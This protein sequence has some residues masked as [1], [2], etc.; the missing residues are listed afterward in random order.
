MV[1]QRPETTGPRRTRLTVRR[2]D[3][4]SVL[5]FS[6]IL[7]VCLFAVLLVGGIVLWTVF[8][9]SGLRANVE[10][11]ITTLLGNEAAGEAVSEEDFRFEASQM[12]KAAFVGGLILVLAG[13]VA[14]VVMAM[15]FNLISDLIGGI[16]IGVESPGP[17]TPVPRSR[18]APATPGAA[19]PRN[20]PVRVPGEVPRSRSGSRP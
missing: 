2:L 19:A 12:F 5:K 4:L 8:S 1:A 11:L 7:Y 3:P 13:T 9:A 17:V 6:A 10:D 20:G 14:N 18:A 15:M 16:T